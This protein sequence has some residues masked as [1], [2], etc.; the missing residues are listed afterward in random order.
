MVRNNDKLQIIIVNKMSNRRNPV[1]II[2]F[3]KNNIFTNIG[4][5]VGL[6]RWVTRAPGGRVP[7]GTP[8]EAAGVDFHHGVPAG[9]GGA[10]NAA[11][12]TV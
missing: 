5:N 4:A 3:I 1:K 12:S 11:F 9:G 7:G 10:E 6:Q 8:R 2:N